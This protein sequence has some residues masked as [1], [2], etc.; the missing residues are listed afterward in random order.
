MPRFIVTGCYTASALQG[1]MA[2]PSDRE[3][4]A[5]DIVSKAGG[6]LESYHVTTGPTDILMVISIDDVTSLGAG[7]MVA[8]AAGAICNVQ[9]QRSFT[10]AEFTKMQEK[11]AGLAAS[12]KAPG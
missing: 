11:A 10:S 6:T 5:R 4:A 9:T 7:L 12:Y 2:N 3:A 8:G 1:M